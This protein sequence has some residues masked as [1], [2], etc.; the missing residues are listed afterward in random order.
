MI[1]FADRIFP[2]KLWRTTGRIRRA[3]A[4]CNAV[5]LV[6]CLSTG[7]GDNRNLTTA[8]SGSQIM[9]T[10]VF[11]KD[12]AVD[13]GLNPAAPP[14]PDRGVAIRLADGQG[15]DATSFA[16]DQAIVLH[17]S[18][19]AGAELL[20]GS[21]DPLA[22]RVMLHLRVADEAATRAERLHSQMEGPERPPAPSTAE[23]GPHYREGGQFKVALREFFQI[24]KRPLRYVVW[25]SLGQ[26]E[27][28]R[29][30]FEVK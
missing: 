16:E 24:D 27:S 14:R 23:F 4:A 1:I 30:E 9:S 22:S 7:C 18:F 2:G 5:L 11:R 3:V 19:Q 20:A 13:L 26:H 10:S 12:Q 6:C 25:A 8:P 15:R 21:A 28:E 29:I 17:G